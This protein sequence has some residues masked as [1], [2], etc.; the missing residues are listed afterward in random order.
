MKEIEDYPNKQYKNTFVLIN[1]FGI[2]IGEKAK[3]RRPNK[4]KRSDQ[5]IL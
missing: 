4:T 3:C 5:L 2:V 1:T